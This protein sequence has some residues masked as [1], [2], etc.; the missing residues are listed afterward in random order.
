MSGKDEEKKWGQVHSWILA[1]TSTGSQTQDCTPDP[2][3]EDTPSL[4]AKLSSFG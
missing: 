1:F 3:D 4:D 2:W